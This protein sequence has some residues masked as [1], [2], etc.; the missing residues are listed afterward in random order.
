ML[1]YPFQWFFAK[2]KK[3]LLVVSLTPNSMAPISLIHALESVRVD[4]N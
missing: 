3:P 2:P 1:Y 4:P